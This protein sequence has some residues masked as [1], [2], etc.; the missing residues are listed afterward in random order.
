MDLSKKKILAARTLE[1]GKSRIIFIKERLSEIKDAITKQDI[2]D[3]YKEGAI[4]IKE[5]KGRRKITKRKRSRGIGKIKKRPNQKK[6][7]YLILTRK[8]RKHLASLK[9][10]GKISKEDLISL[11]K[12][13]RNKQFKSKANLKENLKEVI[14]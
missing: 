3:L 11:R 13:I 2:R 5:I 9:D 8:L 6:R 10:Q 12:R 7:N 4:K 1:V 14:K